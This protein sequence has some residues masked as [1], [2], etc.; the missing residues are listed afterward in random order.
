MPN[1]TTC[2]KCSTL[3]EAGS[4]EQANEADRLCPKCVPKGPLCQDCGKKPA[5]CFGAY[6]GQKPETFA[7]DECCG[8]GNEDGH[9]HPIEDH[10]NHPD[11]QED[12]E[13]EDDFDHERE[14]QDHPERREEE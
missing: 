14:L 3:Y 12:Y 6:E 2:S 9:C 11:N 5:T 1:I 4:E 10:P 13:S 8:H 7:C